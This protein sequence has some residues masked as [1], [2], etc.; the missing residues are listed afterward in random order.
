MGTGVLERWGKRWRRWHSLA[1]VSMQYYIPR[2]SHFDF[3]VLSA[4]PYQFYESIFIFSFCR[5]FELFIFIL[6]HDHLVEKGSGTEYETK[7][8]WVSAGRCINHSSCSYPTKQ[9][10]WFWTDSKFSGFEQN[11]FFFGEHFWDVHEQ[12]FWKECIFFVRWCEKGQMH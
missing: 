11:L 7:D 12:L 5:N 4:Q 3:T 9:W 6:V 8:S 1:E 2:I 10:F